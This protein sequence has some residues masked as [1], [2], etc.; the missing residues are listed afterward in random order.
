MNAKTTFR[1]RAAGL[2]VTSLL[3]VVLFS[4]GCMSE[5]ES[6]EVSS[7]LSRPLA[8]VSLGEMLFCVF[9]VCLVTR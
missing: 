6:Q 2:L 9:L 8:E 4:S 3:A 5:A 1:T 7:F